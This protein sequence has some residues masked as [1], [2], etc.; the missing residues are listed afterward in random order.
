[1]IIAVSRHLTVSMSPAAWE[2]SANTHDSAWDTWHICKT[3]VTSPCTRSRF[4]AKPLHPNCKT[5]F[6]PAGQHG[7]LRHPTPIYGTLPVTGFMAEPERITRRLY[8]DTTGV[9]SHSP[10]PMIGH[11]LTTAPARRSAQEKPHHTS[12]E[13]VIAEQRVIPIPG[14]HVI[15]TGHGA[16]SKLT[17]A[18]YPSMAPG[19]A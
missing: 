6:K 9:R 8:R 12:G 10:D 15:R 2:I 4:Q 5:Q 14:H 13:M 16:W 1:M 11:Y 19:T 7:Q 3:F 18:L 17:K